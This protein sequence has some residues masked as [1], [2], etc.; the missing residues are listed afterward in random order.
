ME[1]H[2]HALQQVV[3]AKKPWCEGQSAFHPSTLVVCGGYPFTDHAALAWGMLRCTWR[4]RQWWYG[5][6]RVQC[7]TVPVEG[8]LLVPQQPAGVVYL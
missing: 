7:G 6:A 3:R 5:W 8:W 4:G 1:M 2:V